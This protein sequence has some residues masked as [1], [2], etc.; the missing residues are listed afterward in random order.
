ML[1]FDRLT[2]GLTRRLGETLED[3]GGS[4]FEP[5]VRLGVIHEKES[6]LA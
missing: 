3:L 5:V 1:D 4:L 2:G 6:V